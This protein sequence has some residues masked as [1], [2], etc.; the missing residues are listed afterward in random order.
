MNTLDRFCRPLVTF[1]VTNPEHRQHYHTFAKH[2]TWGRCPVRFEVPEDTG[3]D[4]VSMIQRQLLDYYMSQDK[5]LL[6][7]AA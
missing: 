6:K 3:L 1:D 5:Q 2:R 7:L 4:L